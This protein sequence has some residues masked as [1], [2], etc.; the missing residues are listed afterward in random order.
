[1]NIHDGCKCYVRFIK[2]EEILFYLR[3]GSHNPSCSVYRTS[4]DPVDRA[5]DDEFRAQAEILVEETKEN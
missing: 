1:M 3:L 2:D 5:A 4:L